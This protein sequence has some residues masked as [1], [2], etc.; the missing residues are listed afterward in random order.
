MKPP[1]VGGFSCVFLWYINYAASV[2]QHEVMLLVVPGTINDCI[3]LILRE[4]FWDGDDN[5]EW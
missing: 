3:A 4:P 5:Y 2:V 1:I